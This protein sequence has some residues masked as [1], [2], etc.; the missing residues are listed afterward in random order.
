MQPLEPRFHF[1]SLLFGL[2]L[3]I[4]VM[5]ILSRRAASENA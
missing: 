2:V 5:Y 3:L 1:L 4:V